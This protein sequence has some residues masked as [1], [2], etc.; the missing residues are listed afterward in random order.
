MLQGEDLSIL[1]EMNLR[2]RKKLT[3]ECS[4][5]E[6]S[7]FLAMPYVQRVENQIFQN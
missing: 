6:A 3:T 4:R 5:E 1:F 7:G 2:N